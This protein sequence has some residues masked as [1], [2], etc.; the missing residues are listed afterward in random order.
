MLALN[1][2]WHSRH[3]VLGMQHRFGNVTITDQKEGVDLYKL[4][5][6]TESWEVHSVKL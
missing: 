6:G 5:K 4:Q 3:L 2:P 1:K